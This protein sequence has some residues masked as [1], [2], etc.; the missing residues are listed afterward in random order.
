MMM[1]CHPSYLPLELMACGALV[2]SNRNPHTGWL[3][4][5]R[6]NCLLAEASPSNIADAVEEGLEDRGLRERLTRESY[7][8][9]LEQY[10]QWDE[11]AEKIYRYM[12]SQS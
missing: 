2:I 6:L 3:L 8:L 4:K 7:R 10:S 1:T 5:D 9:V 12:C 11:Q